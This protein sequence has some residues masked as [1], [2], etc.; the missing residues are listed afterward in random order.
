[1]TDSVTGTSEVPVLDLAEWGDAFV[2]DPYPFY[3]RLRERGPAHRVRLHTGEVVWVVVGFEEAR[4][5]LADPRLSKQWRNA[6]PAFAGP[7]GPSGPE[8][9]VFGMHLLIT[10]PPDHTR[11]RRVAAREFTPRRMESL[12]PL[13]EQTTGRLLDAMAPLGRVDL[14][15]AFSYPLPTTVICELLGIP[16][17]E[18]AAIQGWT[19]ELAHPSGDPEKGFAAAA[20]MN[21]WLTRFVAFKRRFPGQDL[22]SGFLRL[23]DED[24]ERLCEDELRAMVFMLLVTGYETTIHFISNGVHALLTHPEQLAALRAD[25][26]L[27]DNAME[28]MLRYDG[29]GKSPTVRFTTEPIDLGRGCVIP[30]GGEPVLIGLAAGNRDGGRFEDADRFDIRRETTGHLAFGHGPRY[31]L[32]APMARLQGRIALRALLERFPDLALD[33]AAEPLAWYPGMLVRGLRNLPVRFTPS[34]A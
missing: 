18:R 29:P 8:H 25:W 7:T 10:D 24:G 9:S 27:L 17:L 34:H 30:G 21:D 28:E 12:R 23:V 20:A 4:A 33:T 22:T 19:N 31:C 5:A 14:V 6:S 11:L 13:V 1:M 15:R 26:S 2:S 16:V 3:E 32:G